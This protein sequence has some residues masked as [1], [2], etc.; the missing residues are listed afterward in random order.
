MKTNYEKIVAIFTFCLLAATGLAGASAYAA[1]LNVQLESSG[2]IY[3]SSDKIDDRLEKD[4]GVLAYEQSLPTIE[5][6]GPLSDAEAE[7][8]AQQAAQL[9]EKSAAK[10]SEKSAPKGDSLQP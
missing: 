6:A 10:S 9:A 2:P 5:A 3:S 7:K 1:D 8:K 4:G